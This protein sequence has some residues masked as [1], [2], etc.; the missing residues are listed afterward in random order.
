MFV[1]LKHDISNIKQGCLVIEIAEL[2]VYHEFK[3]LN[4]IWTYFFL[5]IF[6]KIRVIDCED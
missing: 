5:N 4:Y 6:F 3:Y 2:A 1:L